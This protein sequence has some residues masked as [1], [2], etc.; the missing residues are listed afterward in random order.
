MTEELEAI[1]SEATRA[2]EAAAS[3]E[4]LEKLNIEYLGRNGKL[5]SLLRGIG[6]LPNDQK[7]LFG[8]SCLGGVQRLAEDGL[9]V[10]GQ[11]PDAPEEP[12]QAA[13]LASQIL[14]L[15][16]REGVRVSGLGDG[17]RGFGFDHFQFLGQCHGGFPRVSDVSGGMGKARGA[18]RGPFGIRRGRAA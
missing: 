16:L 3:S 12:G 17:A 9:L 18:G 15:D 8:Q 14:D 2:V 7:P 11:T 13:A 5:T 4:A 1:E 6:A 10:G